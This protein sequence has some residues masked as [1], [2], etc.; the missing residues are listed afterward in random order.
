MLIKNWK[1]LCNANDRLSFTKF[2]FFK[3]CVEKL[4]KSRRFEGAPSSSVV[5][6]ERYRTPFRNFGNTSK[7]YG[8]KY[9]GMDQKGHKNSMINEVVK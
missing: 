1:I 2:L 4:R 6:L 9:T 7:F 8:N 5:D 3:M